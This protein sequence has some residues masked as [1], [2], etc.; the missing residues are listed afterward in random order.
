[1]INIV[2]SIAIIILSMAIIISSHLHSKHI[3]GDQM[4]WEAQI[5]NNELQLEAININ[6]E[7][8]KSL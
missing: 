3:D 5:E 8:I 2:N 1:M 7:L 4:L 6:L